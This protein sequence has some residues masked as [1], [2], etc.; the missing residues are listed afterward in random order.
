MSSNEAFDVDNFD[1]LIEAVDSI[2]IPIDENPI[3][4]HSHAVPPTLFADDNPSSQPYVA[5][6]TF[7]EKDTKP[8]SLLNEARLLNE[9]EQ[10]N[11]LSAST[12][13]PS[14]IPL[15]LRKKSVASTFPTAH[16]TS[17]ADT[18]D[19]DNPVT[20][21]LQTSEKEPLSLVDDQLAQPLSLPEENQNPYSASELTL[22]AQDNA[23]ILD[24]DTAFEELDSLPL[25][26]TESAGE[27]VDRPV[28]AA[29][30]PAAQPFIADVNFAQTGEPQDTQTLDEINEFD[31][32]LNELD[33]LPLDN[34][35][36]QME[37]AELLDG[38]CE[39][40]EE[41]IDFSL[42]ECATSNTTPTEHDYAGNDL[43]RTAQATVT[44]TPEAFANHDHFA[45]NSTEQTIVLSQQQGPSINEYLKK[46]S[47][48]QPAKKLSLYYL[49]QKFPGLYTVM[50]G[51]MA[52]L[53]FAYILMLPALFGLSM[54][55]AFEML[56]NPFTSNTLLLMLAFFSISLFLFLVSYKLFDLK[57]VEPEGI[58]LDK[59]NA[60]QLLQKLQQLKQE[61]RVPT[62]H[63]VVLTRRHELN[64]IK[65]PRFGL[66]I[67]SKNVL[68]IGYPLLQT[69]TPDHF[70]AALS[71]RLLQYAKRR[72]LVV[73]WSS[74][75]RRTWTLY[76]ESL[77]QRNGVT[78]LLHYCFFAPYASAYRRF[79]VYMTQRDELLA[80]ESALEFCNDRDLVK[81][82]Q[83]IRLTQAMLLQYF[84]PKLDNAIR[85]HLSAP[86]HIRPY[87]HLPV[88]LADLL[89][90]E[91]VDSW[92]IRL[93]QE[94]RN[95]GGAEAPFY[96]R[97]ERMGHTKVSVPKSFD[98]SAA[99]HYFGDEYD[100]MTDHLDKIWADEVQQALFMENL[101][102]QD[103]DIVLPSRL[104]IEPA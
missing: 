59:S 19:L 1:D 47:H 53:G 37:S 80:D 43:T 36:P 83:T 14:D 18:G 102:Q 101:K 42:Q 45:S 4:D 35:A 87:H 44:Q 6:I 100:N 84:W 57:F 39:A 24:V 85:N 30:E 78:D 68:A 52:L 49:S 13:V 61:H 63:Q 96:Y 33:S 3:D 79:A 56:T 82:A 38:F 58:A 71:R 8:S 77:K 11:T 27:A 5:D 34:A 9:L 104:S 81:G 88:A 62:I 94:T 7:D 17:P 90:T 48:K 98:L 29:Q 40:S 12:D 67:W 66:P 31:Q 76:A 70:D 50:T 92:F 97:M 16:V 72:N 89:N 15:L 74:F 25:S 65:V 95:P 69:L 54:F 46:P 41:S 86:G 32:A 55:N 2:E 75:M 93:A 28:F 10:I 99:H 73:N 22:E 103:N 51:G 21:H 20:S 26:S 60:D 23:D 91:N 64:V